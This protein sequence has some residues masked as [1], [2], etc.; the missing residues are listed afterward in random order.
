VKEEARRGTL[1]ELADSVAEGIRGEIVLVGVGASPPEPDGDRWK[2]AALA[3]LSEGLSSREVVKIVSK[4]Y[5]LSKNDVKS[6]LFAEKA[7][8]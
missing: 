1:A 7:E 8:D 2:E 3:M 4:E 6:F 5:G